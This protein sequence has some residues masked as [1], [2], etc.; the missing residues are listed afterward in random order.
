MDTA[1][2][3]ANAHVMRVKLGLP[4]GQLVTNPIP[5]EA[6]I[7]RETLAP[8]I[9][10]ATQDAA[11]HG[12]SGKNVTPYLLQ[13]IFELTEGRSLEANIALVLNNAR[14]AAEIAQEMC[15]LAK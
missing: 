15:K 3:I 9:A 7:A 13:R 12:I 1:A 14:L 2:D 8:I 5:V 4:G 11:D 6:E 10:R